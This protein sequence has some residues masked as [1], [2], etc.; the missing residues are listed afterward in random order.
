[1]KESRTNIPAGVRAPIDETEEPR[2][3]WPEIVTPDWLNEQLKSLSIGL[4]LDMGKVFDEIV[5][6]RLAEMSQLHRA[7]P[8]P[9]PEKSN[10]QHVGVKEV[11]RWW[12]VSERTIWRMIGDGTLKSIPIGTRRRIPMSEVERY[13]KEREARKNVA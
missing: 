10:R 12:A 4:Q 8:P 7:P 3:P 2:E 1:M 5:R 9:S 11:A 13:E 6:R